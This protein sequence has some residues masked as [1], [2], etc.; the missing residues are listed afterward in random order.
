MH[1][2]YQLEPD[3]EQFTLNY[4]QNAWQMNQQKFT[5]TH[6]KLLAHVLEKNPN[7]PDALAMLAMDAYQQHDYQHAINYWQQLLEYFG[8]LL[9][10]ISVVYLTRGLSKD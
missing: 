8:F 1:F 7:Q 4:V 6:R 5:D 3:N 9:L 2:A 10:V